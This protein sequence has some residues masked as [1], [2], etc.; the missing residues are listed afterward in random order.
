MIAKVIVHGRTRNE[1]IQRMRRVLEET[2]ITGIKTT[3]PLHYML[4]YDANYI[5]NRID[6][7]FIGRE[8]PALLAPLKEEVY[9]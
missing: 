1:A 8:L 6:T 3:I 2:V 5:A 9:L 4:M 7:G